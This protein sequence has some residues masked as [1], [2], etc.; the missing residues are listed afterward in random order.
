[1]LINC[2]DTNAVLQYAF[3]GQ[4]SDWKDKI[5]TTRTVAGSDSHTTR[6]SGASQQPSSSLAAKIK[7]PFVVGAQ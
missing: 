7:S 3:I 1:M 6:I 5:C 2:S 4:Q